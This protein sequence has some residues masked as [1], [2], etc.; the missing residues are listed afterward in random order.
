MSELISGLDVPKLIK[1]EVK[2]QYR[3]PANGSFKES[4]WSDFILDEIEDEFT[5]GDLINAGRWDFRLKPRTITLNGIEVPAPFDPKV[6]G[7][8]FFLSPAF[9][10]GYEGKEYD[11]DNDDICILENSGAWRTEDEI[12]QVVAAFRKIFAINNQ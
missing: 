8:Y 2:I 4:E 5:L 11:C 12:K 10:S 3:T 9:S 6:G 7:W 1:D